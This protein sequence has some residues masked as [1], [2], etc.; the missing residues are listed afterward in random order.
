MISNPLVPRMEMKKYLKS[1]MP[2]KIFNSIAISI[3]KIYPLLQLHKASFRHA[4]EKSFL[5]AN[6]PRLPLCYRTAFASCQIQRSRVSPNRWPNCPIAEP[7]CCISL[8]PVVF[9]PINKIGL[10]P[11][12][13]DN[14]K[15]VRLVFT[16]ANS[17]RDAVVRSMELCGDFTSHL[18]N[19]REI[20]RRVSTTIVSSE[21]S[22]YSNRCLRDVLLFRVGLFKPNPT[23]ANPDIFLLSFLSKGVQQG[24]RTITTGNSMERLSPSCR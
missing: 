11:T 23:N 9:S 4:L 24:I 18:R 1:C 8:R 22:A 7:L 16:A 14:G 6:H 2:L 20:S 10:G 13:L 17:A 21:A 5:I 3:E 12:R 15:E 19:N